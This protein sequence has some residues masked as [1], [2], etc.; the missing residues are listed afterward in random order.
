LGRPESVS[1]RGRRIRILRH[2]FS[3]SAICLHPSD[4]DP[5]DHNLC[6]CNT[7]L[8]L[9]PS[10]YSRSS[11]PG[12]L[13]AVALTGPSIC[14]STV[15]RSSSYPRPPSIKT[16]DGGEA[17]TGEANPR[18]R[19]TTL[20]LNSPTSCGN[21]REKRVWVPYQESLAQAS[22]PRRSA[23]RGG[24]DNNGEKSPPI[25]SFSR[26]ITP[27]RTIN[28]CFRTPGIASRALGDDDGD[29]RLRRVSRLEVGPGGG[30]RFGGG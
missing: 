2:R 19:R 21:E 24:G 25:R 12:F 9:I 3:F 14:P 4:Q 6:G 5:M 10:V 11:G 7:T 22:S 30:A 18:H 13:H 28:T 27:L 15:Q 8:R 17:I 23:V 1:H 20:R 29:E 16:E 26:P